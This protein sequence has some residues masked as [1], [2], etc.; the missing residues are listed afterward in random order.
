MWAKHVRLANP[1]ALLL[2]GRWSWGLISKVIRQHGRPPTGPGD[3][4]AYAR[5]VG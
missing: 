1:V 3:L 5:G 4:L 2:L